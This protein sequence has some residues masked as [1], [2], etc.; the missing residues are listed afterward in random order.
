L[1]LKKH[2]HLRQP[3][4]VHAITADFLLEDVWQFPLE[5]D[6]A[7]GDSFAAFQQTYLDAVAL[8][9][10]RGLPGLLFRLRFALG[11]LLGWDSARS[12]APVS[13]RDSLLARYRRETD[14]GGAAERE[15]GAAARFYPVYARADESLAEIANKTVHA[16]LHLGWI[17][18]ENGRYGATLAVYV[19]TRGR[20]TRCYMAAINPFRHR[21]IYPAMLRKTAELWRQRRAPS[22]QQPAT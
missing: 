2:E 1:R 11:K 20:F 9:A 5:A 6:P 7:Q 14:G 19:K 8:L 15:S 22:P 10:R 18:R 21:L 4:R 16:A 12:A 13:G 3:W 17:P